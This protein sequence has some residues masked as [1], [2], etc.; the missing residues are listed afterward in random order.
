MQPRR[1]KCMGPLG[2]PKRAYCMLLD[3]Y[4]CIHDPT[5]TNGNKY[6]NCMSVSKMDRGCA[7]R[8]NQRSWTSSSCR[9]SRRVGCRIAS[10]RARPTAKDQPRVLVT[11]RK[12]THCF[13]SETLI[14]I[15]AKL[16]ADVL[17]RHVACLTR[18]WWRA[19]PVS[20]TDESYWNETTDF[21]N[22]S[23][24]HCGPGNDACSDGNGE[25]V[26][27][28]HGIEPDWPR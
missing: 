7:Y 18:I 25:K 11:P 5:Q 4:F 17:A 15:P 16:W 21:A 3:S 20:R 14:A 1:T 26:R 8:P 13:S 22:Y 6:I 19:R 23:Y 24:V 2:I 9:M 27:L 12:H 28:E 10:R